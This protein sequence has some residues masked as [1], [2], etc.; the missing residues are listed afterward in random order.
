MK[1]TIIMQIKII[2]ITSAATIYC[3]PLNFAEKVTG[4]EV[5]RLPQGH[6]IGHIFKEFLLYQTIV[7]YYA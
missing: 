7:I 5:Q 4:L 6:I 2:I 1:I 3:M